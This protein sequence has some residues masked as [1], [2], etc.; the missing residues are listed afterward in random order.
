M[1]LQRTRTHDEAAID[2][3][4]SPW[5]VPEP[6]A[7]GEIDTPP[8]TRII[9]RRHGNPDGPRL[10]LSHGNGL[11]IDLYYP[12]WS[13]LA[14]R[15][16]LVLYDLRNHGWNSASDIRTHNIPNFVSD[17]EH[18]ARGIDHYFGTKPRIGVFHSLSA[19]VA[20]NQL[21]LGKGN[22]ALVLFDPPIYPPD[23]DPLEIDALW[24]KFA[25]ATRLRQER[26]QTRDELA[27]YIHR[28]PVFARLAPG[29]ADLFART[30]L[31]PASDGNG[32]ELRCPREC[33]ARVFEYIFAYNFEPD[34]RGVAC[35]IKVIG[36]DP[37]TSFSFLPS[38]N[39]NGI[40]GLDYDFVPDTTHFLQMENPQACIAIMLE[41]LEREG[42]V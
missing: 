12:F 21:P 9:L 34:A 1:Q 31:R 15:F 30:T 6:L 3:R 2:M 39:L 19:V 37:T 7:T 17:N 18:V 10:V 4:S 29:V 38:M 11:A 41:F 22:E 14:D 40:V 33:E 32:Y 42:L 5:H 28:S 35:P 20:L 16:D 27:R 13:L 36:G 24:K 8:G 25:I 26:F 23:G